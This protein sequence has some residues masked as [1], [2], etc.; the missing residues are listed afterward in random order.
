MAT[1]MQVAMM[2]VAMVAIA[3]PVSKILKIP[4]SI[5]SNSCKDHN[6]LSLKALSPTRSNGSQV[7]SI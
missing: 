2:R 7:I 3:T 5:F 6:K 1:M 4:T